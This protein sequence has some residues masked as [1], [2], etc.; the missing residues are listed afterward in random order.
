[1]RCL[2]IC[3]FFCATGGLRA[4]TST[5]TQTLML[6]GSGKD[7]PVTWG[8]YC[9]AGQNSGVQT[10]IGVPSCWQLQGFGGYNYGTSTVIADQT[11]EQGI[12]NYTFSVPASWAGQDTQ[13][14]FEGSMTDTTVLMNGTSA[15]VTHQGAFTQFR[16]DVTSMLNYGGSNTI[17]VTVASESSNAS[18]NLAERQGD[19]WDFGGIFRP[20]YLECRPAQSI[21]RVA[22]NALASGSLSALVTLNTITTANN[23]TAAV[24][25]LAGVQVGP[26]LSASVSPGQSTVTLTGSIPGITTWNNESPYLYQLVFK[27]NAGSTLIHAYTQQFGFR[28]IQVLAGNGIYLNGVKIRLKGI[29]KHT[30]WPDSGRTSSAALSAAAIA[31]MKGANITAVRMSHYPPDQHFLNQCDSQGLLILDELTGWQHAYDNATA[32]RMVNEM[33]PRDVNHPCIIAWDNGNEGGWNTTVDGTFDQLDPQDRPV[34]HPG[35]NGTVG[36]VYDKHYPPYYEFQSE[37]EGTNVVLPTEFQ[38]ALYDGGGGASLVDFWNLCLQYPLSAGG[39]I[40]SW[41]DEGIVR[42]DENDIID[43]QTNQAPDGIVGPYWQPEPSYFAV[44]D[45]W[46]PVTIPTAPVLTGAFN[47]QI[48]VHNDYFF[49]SLSG[50]TFAW[51]VQDFPLLA[52][53]T[54]AGAIVSSSGTTTGPPVAPQQSGTLTLSLPAGWSSHAELELSAYDAHGQ[55]LRSWTWPIQ[56]QSAMESANL[57]AAAGTATVITSS[58]AIVLSGSNTQVAISKTTGLIGSVLARGT[59]VSLSGGG[60]VAGT[61][62]FSSL[63][64]AQSGGDEIA[65]AAF[66]GNLQSIVYDMRGNGW[67]KVTST[68]ALSGDYSYIGNTFT[69]PEG[70]V[71]GMRWL[72]DGPEPVWANRL[73]GVSRSV[74]SKTANTD[75][76][77]YLWTFQPYFRGYHSGLEWATIQTS[78]QPI[79]II[80]ETPGLYLRVNTPGNGVTPKNATAA[81]PPGN[82]SLL[83]AISPIGDK[84]DSATAT[85]TGPMSGPAVASGTFTNAAWFYFGSLDSDLEVTNVDASSFGRV[86]ISYNQPV[87]SQALSAANYIFSPATNVYSVTSGTGNTVILNVQPL[88]PYATYNLSLGSIKSATNYPLDGTTSFN[89]AYNDGLTLCLPFDTETG[90]ISPDTSGDDLNATLSNVTLGPGY[91]GSAAV[92]TGGTTSMATMTLPALG[93]FTIAAWVRPVAAGNST[94]PRIMS[95]GNDAVQFFLDYTNPAAP[96]IGFQAG[97]TGSWRSSGATLPALGNWMHV[98]VTYDNTDE[99]TAPTPPIFYLNGVQYAAV[100]SGSSYGTLITGGTAAIGNRT[101]DGMRAFSGSI[102]Q[103]QVY[104]Q[105]LDAAEILG[106]ASIP[107]TETFAQWMSSYGLSGTNP[108]G[109][110]DQ[111]GVPDLLKYALGA[112]PSKFSSTPVQ[113]QIASG[114][115]QIFFPV[116]NNA[117]G[118]TVYVD[119]S[120]TLS[121][122]S[123]T[124]LPSPDV[125][126]WENLGSTTEYRALVPG[127]SSPQFFRVRVT[128]P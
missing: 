88:V 26:T 35:S 77:G 125:E 51:Q 52:S 76:P 3:I 42:T 49:S 94:T 8:F 60:L 50:C 56:S 97:C 5:S 12:Y 124:P 65:T 109:S 114:N 87:S 48:G 23:V 106:L 120:T 63:T 36:G 41:D 22:I 64:V 13:L 126:S 82:L 84:F 38:H 75:V 45:I 17:N 11:S 108:T 73:A 119:S 29:C 117:Q 44:R 111:D 99:T 21:Q 68:F 16:Y 116:A 71:T 74:W 4:Q 83:D 46:S 90:G 107:Q 61:G 102:D 57:P 33:V 62:T 81:L 25:T 1:M 89:I 103:L 86:T 58:T 31:G 37:L 101:V 39:I 78:Q 66:T 104:N 80:A 24:Q 27:L 59:T 113:L 10:T 96:T 110:A 79:N 18:I 98:A 123:W 7:D 92:F 54:T 55:L 95:L 115:F 105:V 34:F 19:F 40:W 20:V 85:N 30:F 2:A 32:A 28:T 128:S 69:Y 9:T 91:S 118:V 43:T 70:N 112:T 93:K 122:S 47:G 14:V 100:Q 121:P 72:G 67:M 15:G 127:I 6:T 53:G